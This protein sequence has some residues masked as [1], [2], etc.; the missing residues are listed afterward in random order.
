LIQAIQTAGP[1]LSYQVFR[2][3]KY[4]TYALLT[5]NIYLF[6]VEEIASAQHA[7]AEWSLGVLVQLFSATLD[8]A[9]WV[10][11]LLLFELETAVLSDDKL[12][13]W[14]KRLIH[15]VRLLCG[16]MIIFAFYGYWG[17]WQAY[18][19]VVELP[20]QNACDALDSGFSLLLAFDDFAPLSSE[21]C[22]LLQGPL[23]QVSSL[24]QVITDAE[25]HQAA[26]L[27]AF[28]DVVNAAAWILVVVVLELEV[29]MQLRGGVPLSLQGGMTAVK[30]LL[31]FTLAGA[32]I[33]WGFAG[34]F[35]DF[36]DAALW[37]FAFVFIELNVFTWQQEL[38]LEHEWEVEQ[39]AA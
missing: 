1:A 11:L 9:A 3:L 2:G 39:G 18:R 16:A 34:D 32:A 28:T 13:G 22:G 31:Y 26:L 35:L 12:I 14:T 17:E 5:V 21:N 19:S 10:V 6:L 25:R 8:T 24:Q 36:W 15:S 7:A 33:Y 29:R 30:G 4:L 38:E 20:L 37:L 27:M 23:V